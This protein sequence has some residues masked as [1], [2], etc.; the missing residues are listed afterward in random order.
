MHAAEQG[1]TFR[2]ESCLIGARMTVATFVGRSLRSAVPP[3]T[4]LAALLV[5]SVAWAEDPGPPETPTTPA[6]SAE[7]TVTPPV[8]PEAEAPPPPLPRIPLDRISYDSLSGVRGNPLGTETMFNL[9]WRHRLFASDSLA[10]R[11]NAIGLGL[12]HTFSPAIVRIGATVEVRP[13][14]VLTLSATAVHMLFNGSFSTL[15]SYDTASAD[16]SDTALDDGKDAN[17]NHPTSGMEV[18]L[19]ALALAKLGPIVFR[20]DLQFFYDDVA[21][22]DGDTVFYTSRLDLLSPNEGFSL[23]NDTDVMWMSDFGLIVGAR[24][25]LGHSFYR[26][27]ELA[28]EDDGSNPNTPMLRVGPAALYTFYDKPGTRFN[29]PSLFLNVAWWMLHRFRTGED[30]SQGIPYIAGGFRF[31]GDLYRSKE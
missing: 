10:L 15:Q 30:V 19:R 23:T 29:K 24:L 14:T 8:D 2:G 7:A 21:L 3:L 20:D 26:E 9:T 13:A 5:S 6:E 12:H 18:V 1:S 27:S 31:E 17:L 22:P 16:F 4:W 11:E 28:L 25:S